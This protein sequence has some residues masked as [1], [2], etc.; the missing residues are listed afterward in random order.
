MSPPETSSSKTSN[1]NKTT[2]TSA[3]ATSTSN[4]IA[5]ASAKSSSSTSATA[6]AAQPATTST[7]GV[8][9]EQLGKR[10][11]IIKDLINKYNNTKPKPSIVDFFQEHIHYYYNFITYESFRK[12]LYRHATKSNIGNGTAKVTKNRNVGKAIEGNITNLAIF[13]TVQNLNSNGSGGPPIRLIRWGILLGSSP[14]KAKPKWQALW[15]SGNGVVSAVAGLDSAG[16]VQTQ[17]FIAECQL[18]VPYAT[19]PQV[20]STYDILLSRPDID[21]VYIPLCTGDRKEWVIKAARLKKHVLCEKPCAL[22][23]KDLNEM[24]KVCRE[25]NVQ[26]MDGVMFMHSDR[27]IGVGNCLSSEDNVGE[28]KRVTSH[29]SLKVGPNYWKNENLADVKK[30]PFGCVGDLGWYCIRYT[31]WAMKYALPTNVSARFLTVRNKKKGDKANQIP[32]EFSCEMSFSKEK[33]SASFYC[34]FL[35][36]LEQWV[37]ISGEKGSVKMSDFVLPFA[38]N[39]ITFELSRASIT[40]SD[41]VK[42]NVEENNRKLTIPE[43]SGNN[44]NSQEAKLFRAFNNI[45]LSGRIDPGWPDIA[46]KTQKVLDAC[47]KS[48]A[49]NGKQIKVK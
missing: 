48:A 17:K 31:L 14:E 33:A 47:M 11:A 29:F 30:E 5:T 9:K 34:S 20:V 37:H 21:A 38:A 42:L 4:Q 7:A 32:T 25:N 2:S 13:P 45:V 16:L 22:N 1:N 3:K 23:G 46:L 15:H 24:I 41:G 35:T 27:L 40:S 6:A 28:I 19:L 8:P 36:E 39:N 26:F 49:E 12:A 10:K 18:Q 44:M 43:Y